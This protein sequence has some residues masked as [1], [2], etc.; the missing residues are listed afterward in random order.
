MRT[1]V[2]KKKTATST[3]MPL[4]SVVMPCFNQ[5][6]YVDEAVQSVLS[7]TYKNIEIV[8]I[9]DGSDEPESIESLRN[10]AGENLRI[11]HLENQGV[12]FARN[13]GIRQ[14]KGDFVLPLDADD[15][16]H[17]TYVEKAVNILSNASNI[18]V[19]YCH[20]EFFGARSGKWML[21]PFD[22]HHIL[23]DNMV[24]NCAMFRKSDLVKTG[25][26]RENMVDGWED[27]DF[28]LSFVENKMNFYCIPEALF[29]YRIKSKS[30]NSGMTI[31]K[32]KR[33]YLQLYHNHR[34]L[35]E[36]N[37]DLLLGEMIESRERLR[38]VRETLP[39]RWLTSIRRYFSKGPFFQ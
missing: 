39:G 4:V 30:R 3:N 12:S 18:H 8:L 28:W 36:Q 9:D 6:A 15:V 11:F 23:L 31:A 5:G 22:K 34:S 29:Y 33:M 14:A 37:L 13:F 19:V 21:N 32:K 16:I 7:Q 25:L 38:K 24:F 2:R 20:A 1:H 27:W 26:Y 10:I 17:P 35:F